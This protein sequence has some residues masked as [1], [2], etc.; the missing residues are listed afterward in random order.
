MKSNILPAVYFSMHANNGRHASVSLKTVAHD[1][2]YLRA[3]LSGKGVSS[4]P[5][6]FADDDRL[7]AI[8]YIRESGRRHK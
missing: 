8:R 1:S 2:P 3:V 7:A 5:N 4:S 6:K